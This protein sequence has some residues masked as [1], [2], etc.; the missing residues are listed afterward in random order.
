[1]SKA[2]THDVR[3]LVAAPVFD[4][5][6]AM[7]EAAEPDP[8]IEVVNELEFDEP[9]MRAPVGCTRL[10]PVEIPV[11]EASGDME[12]STGLVCDDLVG[13][14]GEAGVAM[15]DDNAVRAT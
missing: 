2:P 9:G 15:E 12:V 13:E 3:S 7:A 5:L 6:V 11:A 10:D 8:E 14:D 4:V 1:M